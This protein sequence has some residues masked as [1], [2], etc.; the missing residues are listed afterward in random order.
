MA[1]VLSILAIIL[2]VVGFRLKA[3]TL[4]IIACIMALLTLVPMC[5]VWVEFFWRITDGAKGEVPVLAWFS[6]IFPET[7][8]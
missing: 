4:A 5:P 2:G 8:I 6:V 3:R 7:P 1:K